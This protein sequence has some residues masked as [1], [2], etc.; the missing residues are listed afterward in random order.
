MQVITLCNHLHFL[1]LTKL[2]NYFRIMRNATEMLCR[3]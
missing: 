2:K 1:Y 3:V